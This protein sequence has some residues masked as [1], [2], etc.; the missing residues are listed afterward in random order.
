MAMEYDVNSEKQ[1]VVRAGAKSECYDLTKP[2]GENAL[3]V[4]AEKQDILHQM[5]LP[6]VISN[7]NNTVDLL[8]ISY[9]AVYGFPEQSQVFGLQKCVMD[10]NDKGLVVVT[11]FKDQ[12]SVVVAE[13]VG[14]YRWLIKG[15]ESVAISKLEQFA[16]RAA[17]MSEQALEMA[18]GYQTAAD[19]TS[20]VLQKVM[21]QNAAQVERSAE[22]TRMMKELEAAQ[23]SVAEIQK[24][25]EERLSGMQ[26]EYRRLVKVDEDERS[27]KQTMDIMGAVFGFLGS[28]VSVAASVVNVNGSG[29]AVTQAA[30]TRSQQ[31][32]NDA[33]KKK[34]DL[35]RQFE[36]KEQEIAA[37]EKRVE[38]L[39]A[40]KDAAQ[41]SER[42]RL[43]KEISDARKAVSAAR[44]EKENLEVKKKAAV[45][46]L[47]KLGNM[48]G[49]Q[50]AQL[51]QNAAAGA[52]ASQTRADQMNAIYT[53][54]MNLE[55][56]KTEQVGLLAKYAKQME[57]TVIDQHST[58]AAI[59]SLILAVSCLKKSVVALKD[60]ALFWSSLER[61][62]RALA[63]NSLKE[64]IK[65]LQS[66]DKADRIEA[67]QSPEIMYPIASYMAKWVA[68]LS[69]SRDY[70]A[71]AEKTRTHLNDTV[72]NSDSVSMTRE[73]HWELA[74]KLAG[75]V[76][77]SLTRQISGR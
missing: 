62:C 17:G 68:I 4:T 49:A 44:K 75:E 34:E 56:Q 63:D 10:L 46:K 8:N 2:M 57:A 74:S 40:E 9:H 27:H 77:D 24:S 69:I 38:D 37:L 18:G 41:E 23:E 21:D 31:D 50:G 32:Y 14:V 1:L 47:E 45:D 11:D 67:Y 60:I 52:D 59:Q 22:L 39:V 73:E 35:E 15:M 19:R 53:E 5:D 26:Q 25:I 72:A 71:A 33:E 3:M 42:K 70:L 20:A 76:G 61:S 12:A 54:I 55:K 28:A 6:T 29:S 48:L 66:A 13:L 51:Q 30:D 36:E 7:L 58:E 65:A 43:E 64:D 16:N